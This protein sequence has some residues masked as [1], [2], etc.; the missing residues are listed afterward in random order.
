MA[1]SDILRSMDI[2]DAE[3]PSF[4]DPQYWLDYFPP[5]GRTDLQ[6]FGLACDW[7]RSFITTEK[8]PYYDAFV[9][10]QFRKLKASGKI[11]FGNRPAVFSR[12]EMQP[13]ADHDRRSGEGI[14]HQEYT[15]IKLVVQVVP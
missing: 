8:N 3:I 2:P 4:I 13:C 7:R 1:P 15:L 6:R 10:W 9:R 14:G 12:R 5:H 11:K